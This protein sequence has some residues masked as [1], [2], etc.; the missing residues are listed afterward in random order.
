MRN[1]IERKTTSNF[2]FKKYK[3]LLD[4]KTERNF[5]IS[6]EQDDKLKTKYLDLVHTLIKKKLTDEDEE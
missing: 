5:Q 4:V 2:D 6:Q 1:A 3:Q